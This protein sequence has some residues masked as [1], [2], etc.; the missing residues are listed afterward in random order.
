M[1]IIENNL[2]FFHHKNV[3]IEAR[4]NKITYFCC[5]YTNGHLLLYQWPLASIPTFLVICLLIPSPRCSHEIGQAND[6]VAVF[7][8]L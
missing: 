7:Y 2:L 6:E 8:V 1:K 5:F 4:N 3:G